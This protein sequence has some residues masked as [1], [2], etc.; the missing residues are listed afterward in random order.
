MALNKIIPLIDSDFYLWKKNENVGF[1]RVQVSS[2]VIKFLGFY[3]TQKTTGESKVNGCLL[4]SDPQSITECYSCLLLRMSF[5]CSEW[6]T[7]K[8]IVFNNIL[9]YWKEI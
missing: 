4:Q 6:V 7:G 8:K 1:I 3:D 2:A 5:M 9:Q